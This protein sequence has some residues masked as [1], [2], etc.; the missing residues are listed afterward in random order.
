VTVYVDNGRI[1]GRRNI[2]ILRG[3]GRQSDQICVRQVSLHTAWHAP[4]FGTRPANLPFGDMSIEIRLCSALRSRCFL[5]LVRKVERNSPHGWAVSVLPFALDEGCM[6]E[7]WFCC[8]CLI[9]FVQPCSVHHTRRGFD[10]TWTASSG[11]VIELGPNASR[12]LF[13]TKAGKRYD[14]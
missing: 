14:I 5:R 4:A 7:L 1:A 8:Y 9:S 3:E 2:R 11:C 13:S 6:R 12:P 10:S